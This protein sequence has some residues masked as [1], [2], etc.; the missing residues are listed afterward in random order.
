MSRASLAALFW[1]LD[2]KGAVARTQEAREDVPRHIFASPR[3]R[4]TTLRS[5]G[6]GAR[7]RAPTEYRP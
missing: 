2:R 5:R 1:Q 3:T 4:T 7:A 6:A